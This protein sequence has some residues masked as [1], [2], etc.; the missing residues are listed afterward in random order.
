MHSFFTG[1][2]RLS[3]QS[4]KGI[5]AALDMHDADMHV[6]NLRAQR[7][8][9]RIMQLEE[10]IDTTDAALHK[11]RGQVHGPKAQLEQRERARPQLTALSSKDEL[12][13]R[14]GLIAGRPAPHNEFDQRQENEDE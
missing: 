2:F 1:L 6:A 4:Y 3:P 7:L 10:R 14:A 9:T 11:L 5:R 12:R 8:E 13:K